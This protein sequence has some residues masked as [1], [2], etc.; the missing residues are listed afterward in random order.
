MASR[1]LDVGRR[2]RL[3]E[4]I[5]AEAASCIVVATL[6]ADVIK[7]ATHRRDLAAGGQ[8]SYDL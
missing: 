3:H 4:V 2:D 7:H 8:S 5:I 6:N 1:R